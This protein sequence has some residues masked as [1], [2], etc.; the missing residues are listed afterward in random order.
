M[1]DYAESNRKGKLLEFPKEL[2]LG[3]G[4]VEESKQD[5]FIPINK[6]SMM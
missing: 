5:F 2:L 3:N 6:E 4:E 1:R